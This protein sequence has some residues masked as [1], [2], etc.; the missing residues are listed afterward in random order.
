[1]KYL[2]IAVLL[3][4]SATAFAQKKLP[5]IKATST[6]ASIHE[7]NNPAT[8]W[9]LTPE[10][11]PDVYLTNKLT[12]P[13]TVT[14]KTDID[15]ISVKLKPGQRKDFIVLLNGKDSCHTSIQS[16]PKKDFSSQKPQINDTIPLTINKQ[17]TIYVKAVLNNTDTLNLNFDTGSTELTLL[18]DVLKTKAT[19]AKKLYNT[20]YELK[21]G[22]RTYHTKVYD[23]E[24]SGHDTDGRFGWDLFDGMIVGLN[25]DQN[26]MTV[27]SKL[28]GNIK[29]DKAFTKLPIKYFSSIF[30]V[31]AQISQSST[32]NKDWFLFDS[33]YQMTL[34]LDDDLLHQNSFPASEMPVLSKRLMHGATGNEIPVITAALE[35]FSIDNYTLT[36]VPAQLLTTSKPLRG[37]NIHILGNEVL[38]RFNIYLDFQNNVVYMKPNTHFNDG[39][40]DSK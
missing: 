38:K 19:S 3:L 18:G 6:K 5:V 31:E 1:M 23:T 28:P 17:N 30:F 37:A 9:R 14:F 2:S 4:L 24:L 15:S 35:K 22:S 34:M 27:H 12:Q 36:N 40:I 33:G 10:A 39:Y 20:P 26:I 13:V 32:T 11:K 25:Y 16:P 21:I 8:A 29:R 7:G